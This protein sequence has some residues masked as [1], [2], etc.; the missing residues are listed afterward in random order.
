MNTLYDPELEDNDLDEE[1]NVEEERIDI[2]ALVKKA[3]RSRQI[4]EADVQTI[5]ASADEEQAELLYSRLQKM[6]IRIVS[7]SGETIE[8]L[9]DNSL[10]DVL[11]D[12]LDAEDDEDMDYVSGDVENDPVH[13]YLKEIGQVPL[14][15]AEQEI[16]L[17]TQLAAASVLDEL[18]SDEI[19]ESYDDDTSIH[20]QKMLVNY[21]NLLE[22][23]DRS[24]A[25]AEKIEVEPPDLLALLHEARKIRGNW[26]EVEGSYLRGYL[27]EGN[28]G[29]DDAWTELA[30]QVFEVFTALYLLPASMAERL[31][32]YL[33]EYGRLPDLDTFHNWLSQDTVALEYNEFMI[34]HLAEEAK[35][36][37]TRANL[38]LVV[39]VAKRYMGRGIQLLDLIQEGN[40]GLLRAVEKFDHTKGYKFSTYATWWIRQAVSR[41]IADQARTIRIPVHMYETINKIVRIQRDLVQ[42][43][44]HEPSVEELALELDYLTAEEKEVVRHHLTTGEPLEPVLARKWRQSVSKIRDIL[45]ISMDPMSLETPVGNTEDSTELGDFIEDESVVE[46]VDAA[47]KELLREQIRSVL[48]YLSDREREV[49][50]MRFGLNDGKDHTLEEVG[51]TFGVTRER[52]RQIEAKA[53][54]KLRHPSRSKSLRDYLT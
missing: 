47:S 2:E 14:L 50:E 49:L 1:L 10:L 32:A 27:N 42:K 40:V 37:L 41:A 25:A 7:D 31:E 28:W 9:G 30:E 21:R 20:F 54:R 6:G 17:S 48:N 38:R 4:S 8:D 22:Y 16:W 18:A 3:R 12:P 34:Y 29:Q 11:D 26:Q 33:K 43:L 39:S 36:S 13:T 24:C 35:S 5:L 46:P 19:S 23:W 53:L 52:I 45:R 44:G 15:T 51:K